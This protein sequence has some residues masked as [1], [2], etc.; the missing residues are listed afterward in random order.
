MF[1][2]QNIRVNTWDSADLLGFN[3]LSW[4]CSF[5]FLVYHS[6]YFL[7]I[8]WIS[9]TDKFCKLLF[10]NLSISH[11]FSMKYKPVWS[12]V[13]SVIRHGKIVVLTQLNSA[14][15]MTLWHFEGYVDPIIDLVI[16]GK[17][18]IK[19]RFQC[20]QLLLWENIKLTLFYVAEIIFTD[21]SHYYIDVS[22]HI[23][24]INSL[25][26]LNSS[27]NMTKKFISGWKE[28]YYLRNIK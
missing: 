7:V 6:H 5:L 8:I 25:W 3:T 10:D 27:Q 4:F 20:E 14:L 9:P 21:D 2:C 16:Y 15:T 13:I 1:N 11:V 28:E 19:S 22:T 12:W 26:W 23:L 17:L 18:D 24:V